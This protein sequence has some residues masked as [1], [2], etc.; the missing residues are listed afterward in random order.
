[1]ASSLQVPT[2]SQ[3]LFLDFSSGHGTTS[4][5]PCP[6]PA[7][8]CFSSL[9]IQA[10]FRVLVLSLCSPPHLLSLINFRFGFGPIVPLNPLP[11]SASTAFI[12][13][14]PL[15]IFL[16]LSFWTA[17]LHFLSSSHSVPLAFMNLSSQ[18][19]SWLLL[20]KFFLLLWSS[21]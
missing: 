13:P 4:S 14:N 7:L 20:S 10:P 9:L 8:P 17:L 21:S 6:L 18:P 19:P 5:P 3:I 2:C 1:M 12:L 11:T 15:V 16:P